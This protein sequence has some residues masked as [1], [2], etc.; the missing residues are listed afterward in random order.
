MIS[1]SHVSNGREAI[2]RKQIEAPR[3]GTTGT[4]GVLNGLSMSGLV[5]L[6]TITLIQTII[7]ASNVP[8]ETSSPRM[9][10]GRMPAMIMAI[11]PVIMVLIYGVLNLGCTLENTGGKSP[12]FDI[13]KNIL[14]CPK[15]ITRITELRPAMAAILTIGLSQNML[16]PIALTP[17]AT[18]S[19]TFNV[20]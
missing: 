15:S 10:I 1:L 5:F 16:F 11:V 17:T 7:K 13:V 3:I 18:G 8:I 14:G 12:S 19:G 9:L 2:W 6:R 20:V 4:H